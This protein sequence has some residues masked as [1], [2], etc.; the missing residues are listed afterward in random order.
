LAS[1]FASIARRRHRTSVS[2]FIVDI[3]RAGTMVTAIGL[4]VHNGLILD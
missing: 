4:V 3:I 2:F 1:A